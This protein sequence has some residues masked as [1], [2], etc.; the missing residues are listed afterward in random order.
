MIERMGRE[1]GDE[2]KPPPVG[3]CDGLA[4]DAVPVATTHPVF[5]QQLEAFAVSDADGDAVVWLRRSADPQDARAAE[6]PLRP[7]GEPEVAR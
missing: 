7:R 4:A 5:G 1:I 2:R 6:I 3:S